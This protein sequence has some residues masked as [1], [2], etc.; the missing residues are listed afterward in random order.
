M[1]SNTMKVRTAYSPPPKETPAAI[2][3]VINVKLSL[4]EL[5]SEETVFM[6]AMNI[7]KVGELQDRKLKL[8]GLLERY[9]RYLNNHPKCWRA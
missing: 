9:M 6:N 2:R 8:T 1:K 3:D 5:L 7:G 4:A